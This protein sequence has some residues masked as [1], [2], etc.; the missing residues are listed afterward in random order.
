MIIKNNEKFFVEQGK[1]G[2]FYCRKVGDEVIRYPSVT[3]VL[4]SSKKKSYGSSPS[5]SIGTLVHYHILKRYST[6]LLE[7]PT[8]HIWNTPR[9]E[10]VGRVRRCLDMWENLNLNIRP[11]CIE[12]ALFCKEPRYAGRLD[13]LA[14]IENDLTLIDLKTGMQY[15][16]HVIQ[17]S[18]Y[19]NVLRRKPQVCF[20]YLDSIINRNP[21][22]KAVIRYFTKTE[23]EE[24]Y[25]MFLD[26]YSEFKW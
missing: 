24:G 8:E 22:Q 11:V 20:I 10:V 12:T 1:K 26:K 17:A 23:L 9:E 25:D 6:H 14:Y 5:M 18:S 2:R 3:T 13:M 4:S 7:K 15:D 21:E 16:D 19:W